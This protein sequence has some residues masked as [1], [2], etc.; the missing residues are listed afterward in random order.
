MIG[1]SLG[2]RLSGLSSIGGVVNVLTGFVITDNPDT[3]DT[4][5]AS[6]N[7]AG[8][9][10]S[11]I[12]AAGTDL[13]AVGAA[14]IFAGTGA[15]ASQSLGTLADGGGDL[16]GLN[17][18]ATGL[19][20]DTAYL[21]ALVQDIGSGQYSNVVSGTFTT[22][23]A[24]VGDV[25]THM[26]EQ[27]VFNE[28]TAT[29]TTSIDVSAR[30]AGEKLVFLYCALLPSGMTVNGNA[31]TLELLIDENGAFVDG[32]VYTYVLQAA[33]ITA[34]TVDVVG[35]TLANNPRHAFDFFYTAGG[36]TV[37]AV[38][39]LEG[40]SPASIDAVVSAATNSVALLVFTRGD[41]F[42]GG[43]VT[44]TDAGATTLHQTVGAETS[45]NLG[46]S[47]AIYTDL[48]VGTNTLNWTLGQNPFANT[49][50][51]IVME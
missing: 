8:E 48:A 21:L 28:F 34:G 40:G 46:I 20:D 2:L 3:V 12:Y 26:G 32:G 38:T 24:P 9:V 6:S 39:S 49:G 10:R 37:T 17:I 30:T 18:D 27:V 11:A 19:A 13:D 31:A 36:T 41:G 35:D 25:A 16:S 51:A 15:L 29:P 43:G 22:S 33:D 50:V 47:S 5:T 42:V 1:L 23:P 7:S 14:G 4:F 45:G 44:F